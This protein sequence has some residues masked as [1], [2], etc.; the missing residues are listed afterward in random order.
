MNCALWPAEMQAS[1][2]S[3][4]SLRLPAMMAALI[5]LGIFHDARRLPANRRTVL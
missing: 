1:T 2:S 4:I 3:G 5:G